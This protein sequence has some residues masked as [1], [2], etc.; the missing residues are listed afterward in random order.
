VKPAARASASLASVRLAAASI[1]A[2]AALLLLGC[3]ARFESFPFIATDGTRIDIRESPGRSTE[4]ETLFAPNAH[5]P[6]SPEYRLRAPLVVAANGQAFALSYTSGIEGC[7]L[8]LLSEK[9][10]VLKSVALPVSS[11]T[12]LTFLVPLARGDRIWGW[13]LSAG[14][15]AAGTGSLRMTAAGTAPFVHG[16][17]IQPDGLAVDG[18]V[19][20]RSAKAD[21]VSARITARTREEMAQGAWVIELTP[22]MPAA[23]GT[24]RFTGA[25]G[26][27]AVFDIDSSH[28]SAR[29]SFPRGSIPFL[30]RDVDATLPVAM[31]SIARIPEQSP[32]VT[33]PGLILSW[34]R[35]AWRWPD[36][37]LYAWDRFPNVLILDTASYD[38]QAAMFTRLAYFV[39]KAGHAGAIE[40]VEALAGKHGYNAHDYKPDDLARFFTSARNQGVA[41]TLEEQRLAGLLV[42]N[43][44]IRKTSEGYAP[45][46]GAVISISRSSSPALRKL[47]LTHECSHGAFFS[48]ASFRDASERA[49]GSLS[50]LEKELWTAF[51]ASKDYDTTNHYLVVNEFQSYLIQQERKEVP[52]FQAITLSRMRAGPEPGASLARRLAAEHPE[53]F[54]RS[55]DLLDEALRAAGGPPGGVAATILRAE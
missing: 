19:A 31:V 53:S 9:K 15:T 18:S 36:F 37:E 17:A 29:L 14:T 25:D 7:T 43:G 42:E 13:Q 52:A 39:E 5:T 35:S 23:S 6:A 51:L 8:T 38:V 45:G 20:V 24:V 49:W 44:V 33:D 50:L 55:F 27:S 54:L 10:T 11:G 2:G 1:L 46:E 26:Q 16:F 40:S 48:L 34:E 30:P 28:A 3:S 12:R 47:L 32:I 22:A 21:S 4:T 41:L